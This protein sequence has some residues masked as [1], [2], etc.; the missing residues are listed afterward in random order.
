MKELFIVFGV[1]FRCIPEKAEMCRVWGG[2][3]IGNWKHSFRSKL[4]KRN[5]S[6]PT[7]YNIEIDLLCL[8]RFMPEHKWKNMTF[9]K[10]FLMWKFLFTTTVSYVHLQQGVS[11]LMSKKRQQPKSSHFYAVFRIAP[12][13]QFKWCIRTYSTLHIHGCNLLCFTDSKIAGFFLMNM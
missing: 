12:N 10:L 1:S 3:N 2:G 8:A 5:C 6:L 13:W 4:G 11:W 7:V 9:L